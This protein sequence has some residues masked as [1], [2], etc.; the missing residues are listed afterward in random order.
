METDKLELCKIFWPR[1]VPYHLFTIILYLADENQ[2][3]RATYLLQRLVRINK[4]SLIK[5]ASNSN[6]KRD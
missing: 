4:L 5:K 3:Q 2:S 6:Q 1:E